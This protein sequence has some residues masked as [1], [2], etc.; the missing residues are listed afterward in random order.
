MSARHEAETG[1]WLSG[2]GIEVVWTAA[3]ALV[4][5]T[6]GYALLPGFIRLMGRSG[7]I[8]SVEWSLFILLG[9]GFPVVAMAAG[10][11][12][13][14]MAPSRARMVSAVAGIVVTCFALWSFWTFGP[15]AFVTSLGLAIVSLVVVRWS[16]GEMRA[17]LATRGNFVIL[18]AL[19]AVWEAVLRIAYW[20]DAVGWMTQSA[21]TP[22]LAV[23]V[24][25]GCAVTIAAVSTRSQ[26]ETRERF[27]FSWIDIIPAIVFVVLGF[28]TTPIVEFYHWGFWV[29]PVESIRQGGWLL[30][31]IPS[32]YGFLSVLLP[33]LLPTA[34]G[35]EAIY[36]FQGA[37][38]VITAMLLYVAIASLRPGII[39]RLTALAFTA[40][41]FFFRPRTF[42]LIIPAQDTPAGGP[43]RF[44]W[45][46]AMLLV[47]VWKYYRGDKVRDRTFAI[48]GSVVWLFS[49]AWSAE[50][51]IYT[52]VPWAA[53]YSVFLLQ[54]FFKTRN[55]ESW[56]T[57][58]GRNLAAGF[59]LPI[60]VIAAGIA[61]VTVFYRAFD[62]HSPD[63]KG[64]YEY[65]LLF[66]GGYSAL[67]A[68]SRGA[69]WYLVVLFIVASAI[70]VRFL[71]RE[72]ESSKLVVAVGAWGT[73]WAISSYF[74]SRSH[75]V[76]LLSLIPL[77]MFSTV[78]MLH[79]LSTS[80]ADGWT[81]LLSTVTVPLL[82][83]P[84][85]LTLAHRGFPSLLVR[86]QLP[87][88]KLTLQVPVMDSSL[89]QLA[90]TS[91]VRP[92]DPV[93][94]VSEGKFLMPRWPAPDVS[95]RAV[96]NPRAF[97]PKPYEVINT[98][99]GARRDLYMTRFQHR[100]G[101][102]GWLIQKKSQINPDYQGLL[103]LIEKSFTRTG[104][105]ENEKWTIYR[106][107][108][109]RPVPDL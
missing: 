86:D 52:T 35:W 54:R 69:V 30:W 67:P 14:R 91:G 1:D 12:A 84:I 40:T 109:K 63:W 37:L 108:P 23:V 22:V 71:S 96:T 47:I 72:P 92:A 25:A 107:E 49:V 55:A 81:N 79:L 53:A 27:R 16:T 21:R 61:A 77:L 20:T 82:A 93:F 64:Y 8:E 87:M 51:A 106:Y 48:V 66:S 13:V 32:Q 42:S 75:P 70:V 58:R 85:V 57:N 19:A 99:P 74:V 80:S 31:D 46:Y 38:Y 28:R 76:N 68:D 41:A 60:F 98:L 5:V 11:F 88:S 104:S 102:G 34:N 95:G 43:M 73:I 17:G 45:C 4:F 97:A 3:I 62:G 83:M 6:A 78:L 33:S 56:S 101:E 59:A 29:G 7:R 89:T 9:L 10:F 36:L 65:A 26:G 100:L 94:F 90:F 24:A 50:S 18:I 44:F 15:G 105:F 39:P 2:E 103:G